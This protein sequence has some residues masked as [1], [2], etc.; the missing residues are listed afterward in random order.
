MDD[1]APGAAPSTPSRYR[2]H[3]AGVGVLRVQRDVGSQSTVGFFVTDREFGGGHNRVVAGDTRLRLSNSWS[4]TAQLAH[5]FDL[6]LN[7][8]RRSG[9]AA[10]LE[11]VRSGRNFTYSGSY[12]DISPDFRV[13]LGFVNR[14]DMRQVSQYAGYTFRPEGGRVFSFGPSVS[15]GAIWDHRGVLQDWFGNIDFGID[16]TGPAGFRVSRYEAFERYLGKGFRHRR[17]AASFYTSVGPAVSL[18]GTVGRGLGINYQPVYPEPAFLARSTDA[19]VG[20]NMRPLARLNI[21]EVYYFARLGSAADPGVK[22]RLTRD[23]PVFTN[24]TLRTRVHYQFTRALSL[25]AIVD[26]FGV[27]PNSSLIQQERYKQ[28]TGDV[29][30]TYLVRP[31]TALHFGYN[32]Q[33]ENLLWNPAESLLARNGGPN[34][35]TGKQIFVK[36]NYTLRF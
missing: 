1:R 6:Q 22:A 27:L 13:P 29:L 7:R 15:V 34:F 4:L 20:F 19:S 3:R 8:S 33:R 24:H 25:R 12:L 32:A 16:L 35:V 26:Y 23:S 5:S 11:L 10:R 18:Y 36:L 9:S 2:G 21:D 28:L 14:L 17:N 31:G 30:L